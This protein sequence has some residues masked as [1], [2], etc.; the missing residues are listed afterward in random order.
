MRIYTENMKTYLYTSYRR[1]IFDY[2]YSNVSEGF[3]WKILKKKNEIIK[4]KR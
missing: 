3:D 1:R 4:V 2:R